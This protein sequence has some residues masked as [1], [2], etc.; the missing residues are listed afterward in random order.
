MENGGVVSDKRFLWSGPTLVEERDST[1]SNV[2]KRFFGQGVQGIQGDSF[3]YSKDHLGSIVGLTDETGSLRASYSYDPYGVRTQVSGD[4]SSDFGYTGH[5][6]H[7]ASGLTL[8][9]Y[10]AYDAA[11]A[12]W[13]SRD[14]IGEDGGL[15]LY[16]YVNND[17]ISAAD[18]FG[19]DAWYN[20]LG[21]WFFERGA[22]GGTDRHRRDYDASHEV[23]QD[24]MHD[25]GV[26]KARAA[27]AAKGYPATFSYPYNFGVGDYLY[28]LFT[29]NGTGSFLGSY[30]VRITK[31]PDGT[32]RY[33]VINTT[34]WESGT[35]SPIPGARANSSIEDMFR[36]G[37]RTLNPRSIFNDRMR[38]AYGP[39]GN[40]YQH[41]Y[42]TQ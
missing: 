32:L 36:G 31:C 20:V 42:W 16:D 37:P 40:F 30:E 13:I 26:D 29:L 6:V 23:T 27:W 28:D 8:A 2:T 25:R 7:A 24:L 19:L 22:S 18:P 21:D 5:Y 4:L 33:D 15:N 12:R 38:S 35:R 41:Y 34:G 39:G 17:P 11:L 10:R 1:G 9:P 14:P 3:Y